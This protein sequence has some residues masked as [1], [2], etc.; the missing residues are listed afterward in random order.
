MRDI[1][2][3][4]SEYRSLL[5]SGLLM[6]VG[7]VL[8]RLAMP[9]PLRGYIEL[10][11]PGESERG[12]FV[13]RNLPDWGDR[14]IWLSVLFVII[15]VGIGIFEYFQRVALKKYAAYTVHAMRESCVRSVLEDP[16]VTEK[17]KVA[18]IISRMIGDSARIKVEIS[19]ILV[20]VSQNVMLYLGICIVFFFISV[21]MALFFLAAGLC[22]TL[23]GYL[24]AVPVAA[25]VMKQ[26]KKEGRYAVMIHAALER[27]YQLS[28]IDELNLSSRDL[29]VRT[30]R[31]MAFSA[32]IAHA[33][34]AL[35]TVTALW[36]IVNDVRA[37]R[38]VIGDLFLF[39]AYV[40]MVHRR[41]V[42][43]GRQLARTGKVMAN[44]NRMMSLDNRGKTVDTAPEIRPFVSHIDYSGVSVKSAS[45]GKRT[46]RLKKI[47][48]RINAGEKMA[49]IG[50]DGSGKSTLLQLLSWNIAP[51]KGSITWDGENVLDGSG[52]RPDIFYIA[53]TPVFRP[54]RLWK[55]LGLEG[56]EDPDATRKDLLKRL[57]ARR[58]IKSFSDGL[59]GKTGSSAITVNEARSLL[60]FNALNSDREIVVVDEPVEGLKKAK[61]VSR[62]NGILG[63]I[64]QKTFIAA[65]SRPVM[66]HE[67]D[68][69]VELRKGRIKFDG[70]PAEWKAGKVK[71]G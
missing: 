68:R 22:A 32:L 31:L 60:L 38:L 30:T 59:N 1:W 65:M 29:S 53:D 48:L 7:I 58:L 51:D 12:A 50:R 36:V 66:I 55:L 8:L 42:R 62:I 18:D 46:G 54:A 21:K 33:V 17:T 56:P 13:L 34:L 63:S 52:P 47:D 9:W 40:L 67:F 49:V 41:M 35:I 3:F 64:G 4:G 15:A 6:T 26:R 11:M 16:S 20:H 25:N 24:M 10:F 57:G 44:V 45:R 19:G 14:I 28:D 27:G 70:T 37:G 2:A 69:V 5:A 43:V 39:I 23:I 61:A 71:G